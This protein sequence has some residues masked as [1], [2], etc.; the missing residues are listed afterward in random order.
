VWRKGASVA[1]KLKHKNMDVSLNLRPKDA[2]QMRITPSVY[3]TMS[4]VDALPECLS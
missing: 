3:D 4:D 1:T 2:G